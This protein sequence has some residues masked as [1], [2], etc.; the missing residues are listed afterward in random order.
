MIELLLYLKRFF[1]AGGPLMW[2]LLAVAVALWT[3]IIERYWYHWLVFPKN[4]TML[5]SSWQNITRINHLQIKNLLEKE[6][7]KIRRGLTTS[8]YMIKTLI[9]L[10]P[11]LGLLGTVTGMIHVFETLGFIGTSNPRA[12][13][14][15]V[16]M[17]T[18]PT[19]SGLVVALSG[20]MFSIHLQ[21]RS[22]SM[23]RS[24]SEK[25]TLIIED[26]K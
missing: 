23:V 3:L 18:I 24:A 15:G 14:A 17:A 7:S 25:L 5:Y 22:E 12:M 10:C 20:Y 21:R 13:A 9:A 16:S 26:K 11:L 2:P 1:E 19:M 8:L 6:L 4:L